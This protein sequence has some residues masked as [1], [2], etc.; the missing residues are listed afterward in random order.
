M[1]PWSRSSQGSTTTAGAPPRRLGQVAGIEEVLERLFLPLSAPTLRLVL[2]GP[3]L[4]LKVVFRTHACVHVA[5][6]GGELVERLAP[7]AHLW[8]VGSDLLSL[9]LGL[10][11]LGAQCSDF[12]RPW[13]GT[14]LHCVP[15]LATAAAD[16]GFALHHRTEGAGGGRTQ[17]RAS[18]L[19][20]TSCGRTGRVTSLSLRRPANHWM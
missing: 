19:E 11:E 6:L 13:K 8:L 17:L 9:P 18:V 20:G 15:L 1:L 5:A 14:G 16:V 4:H 7:S 12:L 3:P 10:Q 2:A